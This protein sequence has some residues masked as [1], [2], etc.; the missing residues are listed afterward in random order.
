MAMFDGFQAVFHRSMSIAP[1]M[2]KTRDCRP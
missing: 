2:A 1:N